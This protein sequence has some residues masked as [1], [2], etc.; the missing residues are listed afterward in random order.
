MKPITFVILYLACAASLFA[1]SVVGGRI[2]AMG[3]YGAALSWDPAAIYANPATANSDG[4][5]QLE[6]FATDTSAT[7]PESWGIVVRRPSDSEAMSAGLMFMRRMIKPDTSEIRSSQ[8]L[9]A[10]TDKLYGFPIGGAAKVVWEQR[11][12]GG[13]W[14]S[15]LG[16]DFGFL[17]SLGSIRLGG[18]AKNVVGMKTLSETGR[19]E[20]GAAYKISTFLLT[21]GAASRN[22]YTAAMV[23]QM[24]KNWGYGLD[25]SVSE[26]ASVRVGRYM[27]GGRHGESYGAAL[28]TSDNGIIVGY[29]VRRFK[30][31]P[32]NWTHWLTYTYTAT[33]NN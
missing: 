32:D 1:Q 20:V 6:F 13:K 24:K 7:F 23:D 27:Q 21:S 8:V 3:G 12:P 5:M 4:E 19:Y 14:V 33:G 2:V 9:F 22:L 18:A 28:A 17:L 29:A 11:Y 26:H 31:V 10:L 16:M 30:D 15:G 25:W